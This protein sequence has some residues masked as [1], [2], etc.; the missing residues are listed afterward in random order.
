MS[1]VRGLVTIWVVGLGIAIML[2]LS[3]QYVRA[4]RAWLVWPFA[5]MLRITKAMPTNSLKSFRTLDH[6][7][8]AE[9]VR[10]SWLHEHVTLFRPLFRRWNT[11]Y[12]RNPKCHR[13][14]RLHSPRSHA[15]ALCVPHLCAG[16][17]TSRQPLGR[18]RAPA[19]ASLAVRLSNRFSVVR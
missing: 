15:R 2:Q 6:P 9:L 11:T 18:K 1:L 14:N 13:N 3:P 16:H 4:T 19:S 5:L 8:Y 7:S 10:F 12:R 17:T